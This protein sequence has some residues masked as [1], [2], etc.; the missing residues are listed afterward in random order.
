MSQN[1]RLPQGGYG[2]EGGCSRCAKQRRASEW[3]LGGVGVGKREG[4]CEYTAAA[5]PNSP[6]RPARGG[7]QCGSAHSSNDVTLIKF[8]HMN[9]LPHRIFKK[10]KKKKMF[11][12]L[13]AAQGSRFP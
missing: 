9:L 4:K 3:C 11:P 2:W 13:H 5:I 12:I 1:S 7:K 6:V 8:I 10:K